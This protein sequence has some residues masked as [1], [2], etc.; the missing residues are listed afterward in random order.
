MIRLP[1]QMRHP[2]ASRLSDPCASRNR[3]EAAGAALLRQVA[4]WTDEAAGDGTAGAI[5]IAQLLAREAIAMVGLGSDPVALRQD[6]AAA[7]DMAEQHVAGLARPAGSIGG[8]QTT[9][10][11]TPPAQPSRCVVGS[12]VPGGGVALLSAARTLA[13]LGR[14]TGGTDRHFRL[15]CSVVHRAL[16]EPFRHALQNAGIAPVRVMPRLLDHD[17]PD[18]A[19]VSLPSGEVVDMLA[20]GIVDPLAA[21]QAAL[22]A[23]AAG[24]GAD[25]GSDA[26]MER[27]AREVWE[28]MLAAA[29][30]EPPA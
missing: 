11:R 10:A 7:R 12:V 17:D 28:A 18:Q 19:G 1:C 16:E 9:A 24:L 29:E 20:A 4:E 25:D 6:I 30:A 14:R 3:A 2:A 5:V 8:R 27:R 26:A 22:R 13:A 23:G 15:A 21:L